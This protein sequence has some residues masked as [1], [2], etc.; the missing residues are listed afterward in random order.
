MTESDFENA[1]AE[2]REISFSLGASRSDRTI[3]ASWLERALLSNAGKIC[4][5]NAIIDGTIELLSATI[6]GH[7]SFRHCAFDGFAL[8]YCT[9]AGFFSLNESVVDAIDVRGTSFARAL[10]LRG[11]EIRG[12][13]HLGYVSVGVELDLDKI[14]V[15]EDIY[16]Y[17]MTVAKNV[18]MRD[19]SCNKDAEFSRLKA[20]GQFDV[21]DTTFF[22]DFSLRDGDIGAFAT[23]R[24]VVKKDL[25]LERTRVRSSTFLLARE[26]ATLNCRSLKVGGQLVI[27]DTLVKETTYLEAVECEDLCLLA[28][29]FGGKVSAIGAH[30]FALEITG[31]LFADEVKLNALRCGANVAFTDCNGTVVRFD[32]AL[33]SGTV[34]IGTGG[35]ASVDF[36]DLFF[37][38]TRIGNQLL[39]ERL[40][41]SGVLVLESAKI[42]ADF[43]FI[44]GLVLGGI[45]AMGAAVEGTCSLDGTLVGGP[46]D[47]ASF[48]VGDQLMMVG[49]VF[50][51]DVRIWSIKVG[52]HVDC[53]NAF[54]ECGA[55]FDRAE[56]PGQV[57]LYDVLAADALSFR[58]ATIGALFFDRRLTADSEES[59]FPFRYI[60]VDL[61]GCRYQQ[62]VVNWPNLIN[63]LV[64][65]SGRVLDRQPFFELE[66]YLRSIGIDDWA[67]AV[68]YAARKA[69]GDKA[70]S[71][72]VKAGDRVIR[73]VSGYGVR[74]QNVVRALLIVVAALSIL[75]SFPGMARPTSVLAAHYTCDAAPDFA[76]RLGLAIVSIVPGAPK[77]VDG[78]TISDC[79][80]R[81]GAFLVGPLR[82]GPLNILRAPIHTPTLHF[83]KP[84]IFVGLG[85][86][87]ALILLPFLVSTVMK[88]LRYGAREAQ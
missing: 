4:I 75:F 65:R 32:A 68:Y 29:T 23:E 8:R 44:D 52:S 27:R 47:F 46:A 56:L 1:I 14:T 31:C 80:L 36:R 49:A 50:L 51:S 41:L 70:Q 9:V 21:K 82:V 64:L 42:G 38:G 55:R 25:N 22:G 61:S 30:V 40:R 71:A 79:P 63:A 11:T 60:P 54:F 77:V 45:A 62:I 26:V 83:G 28:S 5:E 67:D 19:A 24:T 20:D 7:V 15:G 33:L 69:V 3:K 17:A 53:R 13:L 39:L 73:F 2:A 37:Y 76:D 18:H 34:G 66:R 48:R 85:Q 86:L 58:D 59:D 72:F 10:W 6:P 74:F 43:Q 12:R 87:A 57:I 35:E 81:A 84:F 16:A 78:W 88:S